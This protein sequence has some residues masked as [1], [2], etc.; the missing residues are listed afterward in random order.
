MG[1]C[2]LGIAQRRQRLLRACTRVRLQHSPAASQPRVLSGNH[3][4][5]MGQGPSLGCV[6][7]AGRVCVCGSVSLGVSVW[8]ALV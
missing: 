2:S 3:P 6:S 1:G 8:V 4:R 7:V 5:G